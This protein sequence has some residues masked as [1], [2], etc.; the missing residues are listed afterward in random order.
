MSE[1]GE[2]G[3]YD[4]GVRSQW[5]GQSVKCTAHLDASVEG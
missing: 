4:A 2:G 5:V 1:W 3:L